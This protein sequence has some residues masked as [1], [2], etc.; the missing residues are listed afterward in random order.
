MSVS[1]SLF[2]CSPVRKA[3][4]D[5]TPGRCANQSD[6][7]YAISGFNIANDLALFFIPVPLLATLQMPPK[8]RIVLVSV[9]TCGVLYDNKLHSHLQNERC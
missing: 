1:L 6:L 4:D 7:S 8:Q 2:Y 3:W 5:S 9:F